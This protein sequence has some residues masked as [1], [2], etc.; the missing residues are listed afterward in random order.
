M[1]LNEIVVYDQK[2]THHVSVIQP[3]T[4]SDT[5]ELVKKLDEPKEEVKQLTDKDGLDRS[6]DAANDISITDN[7][8]YLAGTRIGRASDWY[9]DITNVPTLWNAVPIL[10]QYK[11][12][13]FGMKARPYVGDLPGR[14]IRQPRML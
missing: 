12:F 3:R 5:G 14:R 2:N 1:Y 8:I 13:M 7:T 6:Y 11:P 4:N 9:V 10:N